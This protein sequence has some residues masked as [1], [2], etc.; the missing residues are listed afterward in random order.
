MDNYTIAKYFSLLSKLMEV[1]GE[2]SFRSKTYLIAAYKIEQLTV[3]LQTLYKEKIFAINGIGNAIGNKILEII[4]TGKMK[5]LQE[6]LSKTPEGIME[7][8]KIKGIGPKKIFI[9]WKEMGIENI[10]ELLY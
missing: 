4:D 3:E 1:H 2:N 9:I 10:G 6:L 7:M 5:M 8:M